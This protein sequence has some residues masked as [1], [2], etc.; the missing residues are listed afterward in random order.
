MR[1]ILFVSDMI[2]GIIITYKYYKLATY[3][4]KF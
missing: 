2:E 1:A 3:E 4:Y